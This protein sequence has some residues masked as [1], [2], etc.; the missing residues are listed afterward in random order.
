MAK[1]VGFPA[2]RGRTTL[3]LGL[4]G[5]VLV[6]CAT[7]N[8]QTLPPTDA[9]SG[10]SG[11]KSFGGGTNNGG[12]G[13]LAAAGSGSSGASPFGGGSGGQSSAGAS[14]SNAAFGGSSSGASSGGT[15]SFGGPSAGGTVSSA[16]SAGR[17]GSGSGGAGF[18]GSGSA[19]MTGSA[20]A[21][22]AGATGSAGS[23]GSTGGT[24][25][26]APPWTGGFTYKSGDVVTGVCQNVGGGSTVCTAGKN[27]PWTCYGPTC[28]TYAPGADGWWGNW[29][30]GTACN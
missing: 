14:G 25:C 26:A 21:G 8:D 15:S 11:D 3:S 29:T 16:G 5:L 13:D 12:S 2:I 28:G 10:G 18:A 6:A 7:A 1:F 24:G 22:T 23:G 30:V 20:G 9:D 19:G 27:Y 4:L 17:A